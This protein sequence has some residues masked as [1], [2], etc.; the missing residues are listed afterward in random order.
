MV[1][2]WVRRQDSKFAEQLKGHLFAE[3]KI[4][5]ELDAPGGA[6]EAGETG[7]ESG[8]GSL[9]IGSLRGEGGL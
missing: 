9:G 4:A 8:D 7:E 1:L 6:G 5:V 3:G 2:E